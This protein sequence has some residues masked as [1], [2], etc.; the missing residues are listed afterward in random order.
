M[1]LSENFVLKQV[2]GSYIVLPTGVSTVDFNGMLTLNESG[3]LLWNT[4]K[5]GCDIERL[6]DVLTTEYK[7]SREVARD[8][9]NE[10]LTKLAHSGCI[11]GDLDE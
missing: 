8:D 2:A 4:L 10:F 3:V 6:V 1:K 9:I 11:E 7:V 5:Q